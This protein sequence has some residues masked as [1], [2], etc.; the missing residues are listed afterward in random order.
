MRTIMIFIV[1]LFI[2]VATLADHHRVV[3]AEVK[4]AVTAFNTAYA[5]GKVDDYFSYYAGDAIVYFVD[6][7]LR[8]PDGNVSASKAYESEVWQNI[9]GSWRIVN[10]H[11]SEI[12]DEN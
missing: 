7:R 1:A 11:Y 12:P 3:A 5:D 2:P 10:L 8:T 9:D 4:A 6:Y